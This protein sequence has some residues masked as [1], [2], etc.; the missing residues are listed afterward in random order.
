[1]LLI[2]LLFWLHWIQSFKF[3]LFI[4]AEQ[5][6]IPQQIPSPKTK[7]WKGRVAK[8]FKKIGQGAGSPVSPTAPDSNAMHGVVFPEGATI[9]I[10]L[11][12]CPMVRGFRVRWWCFL[13]NYFF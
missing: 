4:V 1:M 13:I 5:Q 7:T 6:Q 8:Q 3:Y 10:P 12:D 11:E 2:Y 9:G